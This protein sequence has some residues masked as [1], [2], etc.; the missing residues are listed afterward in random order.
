MLTSIA[1]IYF[2]MYILINCSE[3]PF[4]GNG[5]HVF[6]WLNFFYFVSERTQRTH[7]TMFFSE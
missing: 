7:F 6:Y 1:V 4:I 2:E 5:E 3:R